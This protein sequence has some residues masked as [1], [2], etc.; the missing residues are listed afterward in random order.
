MAYITPNQLSARLGSTLYARLT[1]R[2][3]GTTAS[4]TVAQQLIDEAQA[5]ADS[6]LAARYATPV[7]LAARPEL[8]AVLQARVLDLAE[9][10][11]W[12]SSP[13][14][15]DLPARVKALYANAISWFHEVVRGSVVLPAA[16]PPPGPQA[17][18]DAPLWQSPPRVIN[19]TTLDGL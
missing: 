15:S 8:L 12:R 13:F 6:Y 11:A 18:S 10:G 7:D 14:V 17:T 4:V 9:Y 5:E 3:N 1:D 16:A 19:R 2:V